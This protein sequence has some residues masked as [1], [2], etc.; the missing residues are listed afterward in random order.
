MIDILVP[1]SP[2]ELIDKLTILRLKSEKIVDA[3]KLDKVRKE[4]SILQ[5]VADKNIQSSPKLNALWQE[6]YAINADLWAIEDD[7]RAFDARNDFGSG[8]IALAR[9]VYEVNDRRASIKLKINTLLGSEIV[10]VKSYH[11]GA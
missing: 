9:S 7:I 4:L 3:D 6:L 2:G 1:I 11:K 8:F 10:E 5:S